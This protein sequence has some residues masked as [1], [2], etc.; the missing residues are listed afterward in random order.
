MTVTVWEQ[1]YLGRP[2]VRG[3]RGPEAFD[4]WG[5]VR[6]VQAEIYGRVCPDVD[7]DGL[8]V[9]AVARAFQH[10]PER[11]RWR[12]VEDAAEGDCV[13]MAHARYPSHVGVW[14]DVDGGGVL[15]CLRHAGVVFSSLQSL[16]HE[17]WGRIE[18]YRYAG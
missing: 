7:I 11:A 18:F 4:C 9:A 10:H 6:A 3:A 8:D 17:R 14:L 13:L 1:R 5:L 16:R 2:W 12:A 15:H